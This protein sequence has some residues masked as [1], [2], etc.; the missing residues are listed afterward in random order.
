MN[1]GQ[2][3][4]EWQLSISSPP[5]SHIL[6][7]FYFL[8]TDVAASLLGIGLGIKPT[9]EKKKALPYTIPIGTHTY[10]K[11][12]LIYLQFP[13]LAVELTV[14]ISLHYNTF[15]ILNPVGSFC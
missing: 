12:T 6:S 11:F 13:P 2:A 14:W 10:H 15:F 8:L 9:K 3:I 5:L 1:N 7:A 4:A